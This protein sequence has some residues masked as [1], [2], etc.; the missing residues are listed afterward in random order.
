ML[1][2]AGASAGPGVSIV[3]ANLAA[4]LAR[5]RGDVIL[6]CAD[7]ESSLSPQLLGLANGRGLA[8]VISGR[9]HGR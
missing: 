1:L 5:I 7:L 9:R 6:V 2:V 4:T 3:A 8:E